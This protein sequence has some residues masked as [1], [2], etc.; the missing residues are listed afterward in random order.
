MASPKRGE[1]RPNEESGADAASPPSATQSFV[2]EQ[3]LKAILKASIAE[4][5]EPLETQLKEDVAGI[6]RGIANLFREVDELRAQNKNAEERIKVLE[7]DVAR[8]LR[9]AEYQD[10]PPC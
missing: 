7:R 10:R 4:G 3:R 6:N 1:K 9:R 2:S 5:L 8:L